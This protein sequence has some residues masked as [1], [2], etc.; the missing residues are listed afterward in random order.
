MHARKGWRL[1]A[2]R[3]VAGRKTVRAVRLAAARLRRPALVAVAVIA[4]SS[5]LGV[6]AFAAAGF[7]QQYGA[8]RDAVSI[9]EWQ[10]RPLSF[11]ASDCRECHAGAAAASA[12]QPH[13]G[14]LCESCHVP[15]V[16]HPGPVPGAVQMLPVATDRDCEACHARTPAR[17]D[18]FAQVALERHYTGAKC[19][20]CHDAHTSTAVKPLEVVHPLANMPPCSTCHAPL[21]LKSYP[22]NHEPADDEVCLACHRQGASGS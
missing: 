18:A 19:L 15:T 21:G 10:L 6:G 3:R 20:S 1:A 9:R 8:P 7:H 11:L 5:V 14:L 17:P 16:A 13:E 12:G 4:L 2:R 22:A